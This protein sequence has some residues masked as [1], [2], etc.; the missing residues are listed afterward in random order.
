MTTRY[1]VSRFTFASFA[2]LTAV[3]GLAD[4]KTRRG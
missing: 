3:C 1:D 2:F 4:K